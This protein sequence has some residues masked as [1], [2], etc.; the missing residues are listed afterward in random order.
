MTSNSRR[1]N[2]GDMYEDLTGI[3]N[4]A[5]PKLMKQA[6]EDKKRY[7]DAV[8]DEQERQDNSCE[9]DLDKLGMAARHY[10]GKAAKRAHMIG[11]VHARCS[12]KINGLKF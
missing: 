11:L 3:E 10:T 6:V 2:L 4:F 1:T 8:L 7:V 5:T 12:E 9:F